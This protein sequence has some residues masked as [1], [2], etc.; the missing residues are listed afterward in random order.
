MAKRRALVCQ[1][2]KPPA[3]DEC[4][5]Y[6]AQRCRINSYAADISDGMQAHDS[7]PSVAPGR[8]LSTLPALA[9]PDRRWC[10]SA[11]TLLE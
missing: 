5:E 6:T 9:R 10:V 4:A 8:E 11:K 7:G 3:I 2:Q 1:P